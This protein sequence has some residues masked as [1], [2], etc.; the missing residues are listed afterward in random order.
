M[1]FNVENFP[2]T[3]TLNFLFVRKSLTTFNNF[4]FIPKF[5]NFNNNLKCGT[6]SNAF[7][8]SKYIKSTG[9]PDPKY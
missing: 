4:P 2:S 7:E 3:D 1:S 6:L 5:Y 9:A 8:K